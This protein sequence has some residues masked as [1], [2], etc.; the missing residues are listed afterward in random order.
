MT[1]RDYLRYTRGNNPDT[2]ELIRLVRVNLGGLVMTLAAEG[3][4]D[5]FET[6][7]AAAANQPDNMA[8]ALD[9]V[10]AYITDGID[11]IG[12]QGPLEKIGMAMA[13]VMLNNLKLFESVSG[14]TEGGDVDGESD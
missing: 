2:D 8:E 4:L 5:A 14:L 3:T 7:R 10:T 9:K 1:Y 6:F 11:V 13:K 12:E